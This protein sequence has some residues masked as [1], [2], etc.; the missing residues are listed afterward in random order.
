LKVSRKALKQ[1]GEGLEQAIRRDMLGAIQTGLDKAVFLGTGADGQPLGIIPGAVTYGITATGVDA[2]ASY[3]AFRAA[4]IRFMVANAAASPADCRLL[5]R[6]ETWGVLDGEIFDEG[7]GVTEYDRLAKAMPQIVA[8]A[9]ALAAPSGSPAAASAVLTTTAGGLPPAFF[10]I[11]GGIDM[12]R[13]P[14][15]DAQSGG[16]RLTG[17]VTADVTVAR[18]SQI[19]ILTG[20]EAAA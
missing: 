5:I 4:A 7:S 11:W 9:N 19:E 14:F 12:I 18:G 13:D 2:T 17:L 20:I 15:A 8:S 1:S 16:L 10:A 6:P 3:A